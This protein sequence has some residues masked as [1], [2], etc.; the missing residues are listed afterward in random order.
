[1]Q[2]AYKILHAL[3]QLNKHFPGLFFSQLLLHYDPIE[4]LSFRREL[5]DEIDSVSFVEG[6]L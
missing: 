5:K 4:Q 3:K 6:I 1:M 2:T